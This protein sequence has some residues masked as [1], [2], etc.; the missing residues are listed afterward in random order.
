MVAV[1]KHIGTTLV[2]PVMV[3]LSVVL[4]PALIWVGA[5]IGIRQAFVKRRASRRLVTARVACRINSDCPPG[6]RCV[7]GRCIPVIAES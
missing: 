4:M 3:V 6:H 7:E 1:L 5:G 2:T